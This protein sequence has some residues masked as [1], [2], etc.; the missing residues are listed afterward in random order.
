M[1][2]VSENDDTMSSNLTTMARVCQNPK[3]SRRRCELP[4]GANLR[5]CARCVANNRTDP[6]RYCSIECQH[7]HWPVHKV[8][9]RPTPE[10]DQPVSTITPTFTSEFP[11]Q[12]A[13]MAKFVVASN[14]PGTTNVVNVPKTVAEG[15]VASDRTVPYQRDAISTSIVNFFEAITATMAAKDENVS[16][17]YMSGVGAV[18]RKPDGTRMP[19][20]MNLFWSPIFR[21]NKVWMSNSHGTGQMDLPPNW[22]T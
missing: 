2:S 4:R 16:F 19:G 17:V 5:K 11:N 3:C 12:K 7:A 8:Q 6:G 22:T 18:L 13:L 20:P 14:K 21:P 1:A 9:C 10:K 15:P